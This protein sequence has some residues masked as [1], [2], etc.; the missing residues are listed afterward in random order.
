M[1]TPAQIITDN[2][3]EFTRIFNLPVDEFMDP[4]LTVITRKFSI[5]IIKL[6]DWMAAHKG[7]RDGSLEDFIRKT[8]GE[9]AVRFIWEN[10]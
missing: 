9:D 1:K 6:D 2:R 8:Y 5:D 7:Y 4:L 10:I 3:R